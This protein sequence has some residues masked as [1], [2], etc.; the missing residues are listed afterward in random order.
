M[1]IQHTVIDALSE[2][3]EV[4]E[5]EPLGRYT[6]YKTGGPADALVIPRTNESMP[7][8]VALA[9]DEGIPLT[10]I[11]GGS[12]LL[13]GDRGIE[14]IVIRICEDES[15]HAVISI[16]EN[17]TIYA[18]AMAGKENLI[19]FAIDSG[20]G[21]IEFMAGIPGC[22]G[23]GIVMN[24]GTYMGSFADILADVDVIDA[25]GVKHVISIDKA[26]SSYRHMDIGEEII[27]TG[28]RFRLPEADDRAAVRARVEEILADRRK[29]HP[30]DYPSAG[31]VFKNPDGHSSWKL[32]NDAGLKGKTVG[33]ASVSDLHTNFIININK[34]TSRDIRDLIALVRETVYNK[35]GIHL[36][37][38][39]KMVGLF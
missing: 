34:A 27:I 39:I 21:G 37:A 2:W 8:I 30:L 10:V 12:N 29:K 5:A 15:R 13:V 11:G 20:F 23:G 17:G 19:N 7:Y 16:L 32:I 33:G 24:A 35:F 28:A 14:G 31:S 36:E 1:K 3:G 9:R 26:M 22:L 25:C 38:E 18:D 4:R 6:T